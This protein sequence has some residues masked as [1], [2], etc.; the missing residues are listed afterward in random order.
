MTVIQQL[1][2][3]NPQYHAFNYFY[4]TFDYNYLYFAVLL[5]IEDSRS[6]FCVF[7]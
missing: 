7:R 2:I 4:K 3:N 1:V 5:L 6:N